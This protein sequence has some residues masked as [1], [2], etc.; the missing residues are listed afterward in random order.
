MAKVS[1]SKV[2]TGIKK[3]IVED[4]PLV[5]Q[6]VSRD[7][8]FDKPVMAVSASSALTGKPVN[9]VTKSHI[10]ATAIS[11]PNGWAVKK[12]LKVSPLYNKAEGVYLFTLSDAGK[13]LKKGP[14]NIAI[15]VTFST[16]KVAYRGQTLVQLRID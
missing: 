5:V 10:K 11:T 12:K 4:H 2:K 7:Y 9:G 15:H 3:I 8:G 1:K 14:Y 6:C 16:G 13:D